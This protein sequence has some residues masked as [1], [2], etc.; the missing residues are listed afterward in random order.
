M[1]N[2]IKNTMKNNL[3]EMILKINP[4]Y[5]YATEYVDNLIKFVDLVSCQNPL[6]YFLTGEYEEITY[7]KKSI[8]GATLIFKQKRYNRYGALIIDQGNCILKF[9][10]S[11]AKKDNI[12]KMMEDF[13]K[14][15]P[16]FKVFD[17]KEDILSN[18]QIQDFNIFE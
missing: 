2:K 9:D 10:L 14:S 6:S 17:H 7:F 16:K 8:S 1:K 5:L 4:N 13:D 12:I 11:E 3:E 18:K 15:N